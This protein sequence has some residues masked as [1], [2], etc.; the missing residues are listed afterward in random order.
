LD[1]I[2]LTLETV[3]PSFGVGIPKLHSWTLSVYRPEVFRVGFEWSLGG[4]GIESK[5]LA[6]Q[7]LNTYEPPFGE[8][9]LMGH[10]ATPIHN[11]GLVVSS[12]GDITAT[13]SIPGLITIPSDGAS[14]HNVTITVLELDAE[15]SWISVPKKSPKAHL[16]V[17]SLHFHLP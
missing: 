11:R 7:M 13:F 5:K 16:I 2:P 3:T 10:T 4:G 8:E 17:R 9:E 12:K 6:R 1:D 14:W 15:M